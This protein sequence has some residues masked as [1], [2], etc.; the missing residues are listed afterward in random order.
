MAEYS[1]NHSDK[2]RGGY[3]KNNDRNSSRPYRSDCSDRNEGGYTKRD[4]DRPYGDKKKPFDKN[5]GGSKRFDERKN[6]G[7][8]RGERSFDRK[9]NGPRKNFDRDQNKRGYQGERKDRNFTAE[10]QNPSGDYRPS[11]NAPEIDTDVT[12]KELEN[13]T[14]RALRQLE[15]Q[16]AD[17]VA[18]HLVMV[19]RYLDI[20]PDFA[21]EHAVAA[22]KRAGRIGVVREV[23]GIAAYAAEDFE[24]A[25]RELR[26]H[27]RISGSNE[28]LALL[29]DCERALGRIEKALT[30]AEE[31]K[32]EEVPAAVRSEV[33]I[34]VSGIYSDQGELKKA[35]KALEIP[36]L[37]PKRGFDY[38]P[39]LFNTY[40]ELLEQDGRSKEA[41]R[42]ARLALMTEAALGQ[43]DFVEPE[44]FDIFT[45]QDLLEP[46]EPS[47]DLEAA[48]GQAPAAEAAEAGTEADAAD[49]TETEATDAVTVEEPEANEDG[50]LFEVDETLTTAE[51]VVSED[52]A[53]EE[54]LF[55]LSDEAAEGDRD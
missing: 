24:L 35:L 15:A 26:T 29:V 54:A 37:N 40:A 7:N 48:E 12:G 6:N 43:G 52:Q 39:R 17:T 21:L 5:R 14:L 55:E 53:E 31:A 47:V 46:E 49:V 8:G 36:E 30:L 25:L 1:R 20:D 50:A 3:K 41:A 2:N 10:A 27:R 18:K 33:A 19:G 45:E 51:T 23:V 42:W 4:G 28:H 22:S 38:S 11:K 32:N 34:V 44:I 16:N 9:G 13:W